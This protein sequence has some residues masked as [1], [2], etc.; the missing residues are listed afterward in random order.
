VL[1]GKKW[2]VT[3]LGHPAAKIAVFLGLSHPDAGRRERHSMVL[4]PLD[5][6][7]V[8]IRRMLPC[9]GDYDPPYGHGEV[10]FDGADVNLRDE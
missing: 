6:P 10:W 4:V 2:W 8:T 7:G 1:D 5:A 3:G 9:F